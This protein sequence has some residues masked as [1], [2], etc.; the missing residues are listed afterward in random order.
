[1]TMEKWQQCAA[2]HFNANAS[3]EA[4]GLLVVVKGRKHYWPCRNLAAKPSDQF[5]LHPSDYAAAEDS[6]EVL[7]IIHSHPQSFAVLSELDR[8]GVE[9]T[10][11][12]WYIYSLLTNEWSESF[13]PSG[14]VPP[15][16]GRQWSWGL[17]DCWSLARDW[18]LK[19]GIDMRDWSRPA[20]I[21]EFEA[22]PIF[23]QCWKES[24]FCELDENETLRKSDLLLMS[25]G[26]HGLNHCG[27][28][29]GDQ[30]IL[31]HC[32]NRLSSRDMYGGW[33]LKCTGRRLRYAA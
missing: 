2:E 20:T 13:L 18:Y 6:G 29:V 10:G 28:Y 17:T 12:P 24:G 25:I 14:Y 30:A 22:A 15:L 5:I 11:L 9:R 26:S 21:D 19:N 27:V 16:I 1:M 8:V 32:R 7:A 33:L 3:Q 4:C 31:H 23:D